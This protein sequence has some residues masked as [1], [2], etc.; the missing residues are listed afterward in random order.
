MKSAGVMRSI[1]G[2]SLNNVVI[3][4]AIA[5]VEK[6][7]FY[8]FLKTHVFR[9]ICGITVP[10]VFLLFSSID[11]S[12]EMQQEQQ[13]TTDFSETMRFTII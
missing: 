10:V 12:K 4:F 1:A 11:K 8:T 7:S 9:K 13:Y 3:V 5:Q 6:N 2:R